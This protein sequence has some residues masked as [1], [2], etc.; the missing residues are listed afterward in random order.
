MGGVF[1][2]VLFDSCLGFKRTSTEVSGLYWEWWMSLSWLQMRPALSRFLCRRLWLVPFMSVPPCVSVFPCRMMLSYIWTF[3]TRLYEAIRSDINDGAINFKQN[4]NCLFRLMWLVVF[5]S[6]VV[7]S[8]CFLKDFQ[9]FITGWWDATL[10]SLAF[11]ITIILFTIF[12]NREL[13]HH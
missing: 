3:M 11:M 2:T 4:N 13:L 12:S 7:F 9:S 10:F 8:K 6:L 1:L 5:R